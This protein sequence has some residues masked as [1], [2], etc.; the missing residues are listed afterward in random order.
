M[1]NGE[2][3]PLPPAKGLPVKINY[4]EDVDEPRFDPA[5]HLNLEMPDYVRVFPDFKKMKKT[6]EFFGDANGSKFAYSSPFQVFSEE[7][8]RVL[9][10][11]IKRE[12]K[13]GVP[14]SSSRGNKIALRGLYYMSPF[15]RDIQTCKELREHFK[16][17]AGEELVP[18]PSLMNSPQINLSVTGAVGP[19]DPWHYD[20][21]AYTGVVLLCDID[22]ME[23]GNLEIMNHDKHHAI[24]LLAE[25]KPY[26]AEVVGYEKPG[27]MILAQGSEIL[28]HVTPVT[29]IMTRV[30]LIFGYSPANAF[31]PPKTILKTFQKVDQIHKMANYE[32][33]REKAWQGQQ[34]LNHFVDTIHYT[35]NGDYLGEK[36][37]SVAKE[38]QRAANLLMEKEDDTIRIFDEVNGRVEVNYDKVADQKFH[39]NGHNGSTNGLNSDGGSSNGSSD[40]EYA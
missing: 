4:Y 13:Q 33:F 12:E 24:D 2:A 17:I 25:G 11:I 3:L 15:V 1:H 10:K 40:V 31:Q 18:H 28:H 29:N 27:K 37:Q 19:V 20:S 8:M 7:G 9:K 16:A 26:N 5:I 22:K 23:G 34:C 36:L 35:T 30:S 14:P 21:V 32:F 6:P 38:L 39:S